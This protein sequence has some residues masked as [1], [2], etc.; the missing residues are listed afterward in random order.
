MGQLPMERVT[1]DSVFNRVGVDYAG[2]V[3]IKH[4][5]VCKPTVIKA[6]VCVLVSL[7]VKA[8]H[9][10]LVSD[11][12]TDAF[13]AS[14][15]CFI[16]RRGKSVLIWSDDG[17]NF[18]GAARELKELAQFLKLQKTQNIISEFCSTQNIEWKFIPEHAPHFSGI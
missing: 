6:Y 14:L 9:L 1:S 7:S 15:R 5:F 3:Y 13:V 18:V 11:L 10:E 2:P 8:V 4:G 17:S 16:A 12:S